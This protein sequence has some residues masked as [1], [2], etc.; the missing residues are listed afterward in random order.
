MMLREMSLTAVMAA[1]DFR[2]EVRISA[3]LVLALAAVLAPLLVLFG[4]RYGIIT[5]LRE[6]LRRNPTSLELRPLVQGQFGSN[7]FSQLAAQPGVGFLVPSTRFLAAT[8]SLGRDGNSDETFVQAEMVPTT[9]NDP[10]LQRIWPGTLPQREVILSQSAAE[11]L[12]VVAGDVVAGR[13]ARFV[14]E[15]R[16]SVLL[17]LTVRA[18]LSPDLFPWE[19][20]F[21]VPRLLE[22]VEDYREGFAVPEFAAD[23]KSRPDGERRYASFRLY[24]RTIDD[25]EP[26]RDWLAAR[27][28]DTSTR[29]PEIRLVQRLDRAVGLLFAIIAGLGGAGFVLS[30]MISL[31]GNVERKRYE[32][33]VLRLLGLPS[34]ALAAFPAVQA[35]LIAVSGCMAAGLVCLIVI[36][37]INALFASGLVASQEVCILP[38]AAFAAACG[39]TL[40][41]S[42]GAAT[43]AGWRAAGFSPAEGL[44]HE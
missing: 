28:I 29:L 15:E 16:Q 19:A 38:P 1:A 11:K 39:L 3:C 42:L 26:L 12:R 41:L 32:I 24:A 34:R 10:L 40:L 20:A 36:P 37:S 33:S 8:I 43:V 6:D 18:V 30:L 31:W 17:P 14:G 9:A 23:G 27:G 25:V 7:F 5:G 44:R 21:L 22:L 2:Y 13:L 4:L 35:M